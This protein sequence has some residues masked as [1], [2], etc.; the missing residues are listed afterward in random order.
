M[1]PVKEAN[2]VPPLRFNVYKLTQEQTK[3]MGRTL[4]QIEADPHNHK[5]G[6]AKVIN[7]N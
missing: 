1:N 3:N 5:V 4:R 2:I 6:M 7:F